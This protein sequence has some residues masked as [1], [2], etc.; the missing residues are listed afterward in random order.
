METDWPDQALFLMMRA[1]E[2]TA[3]TAP[4]VKSAAWLQAIWAG[5]VGGM[6]SKH[7]R[8]PT[9]TTDGPLLFFCYAM[10]LHERDGEETLRKE[11]LCG[12]ST[13]VSIM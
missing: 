2:G 8:K 11:K 12:S 9:H 13:Q 4:V 1:L 6:I 10:W 5:S 7:L 3:N